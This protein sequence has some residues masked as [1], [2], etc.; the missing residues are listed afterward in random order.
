MEAPGRIWFGYI[1]AVAIALVGLVTLDLLAIGLAALVLVATVLGEWYRGRRAALS[2][3]A[4]HADLPELVSRWARG[5][6][7][8]RGFPRPEAVPG[9]VRV[10]VGEP[11]R[12]V[13]WVT[14]DAPDTLAGLVDAAGA[15]PEAWLSVVTDSPG[16]VRPWFVEGGL[17]ADT[18]EA[19]MSIDLV[20]HAVRELPDGYRAEVEREGGVITVTVRAGEGAAA[21]GRIAVIGTDAV[22][23]RVHTDPEHRSRGL[24]GAVM[25]LLVSAAREAGAARGLL[26][27]SDLG[28]PL[29]AG[30][31]WHVEARLV[32]ARSATPPTSVES[33]HG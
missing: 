23:D 29:Y 6:A 32:T 14:T 16:G 22:A 28:E 3:A 17:E 5:W 30:L 26:V 9:G 33:R 1:A 15:T 20:D 31:G 4:Q 2:A 24:G 27:A 19:L 11:G 18:E 10:E 25:S 13:E 7:Y 12:R 8:S 21:T